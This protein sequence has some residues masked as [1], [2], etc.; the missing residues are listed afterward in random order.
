MTARKFLINWFDIGSEYTDQDEIGNFAPV[1]GEIANS[2]Y[3]DISNCEI[4]ELLE[5]ME[6][7]A[8]QRITQ[9]MIV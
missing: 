3:D 6:S 8:N 9:E 2:L 4:D 5:I 7:Y 1:D